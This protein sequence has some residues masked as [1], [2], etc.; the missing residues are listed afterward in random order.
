MNNLRVNEESR[1]NYECAAKSVG[2]SE[3]I[4]RVNTEY[5]PVL[6]ESSEND[7]NESIS[8]RENYERRT[9]RR[10]RSD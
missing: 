10:L 9:R 5:V 3:Q 7:A 1:V 2:R 8:Q 6:Y 4:S